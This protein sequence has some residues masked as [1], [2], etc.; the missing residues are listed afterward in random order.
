MSTGEGEIMTMHP[1]M[2]YRITTLELEQAAVRAERARMAAE[3][4]DQIVR[5]DG[6]LRRALRRLQISRAT[7]TAAPRA[8]PATPASESPAPST[9]TAVA[10][11]PAPAPASEPA[12][13]APVAQLASATVDA[14]RAGAARDREL[15]G[16]APHAA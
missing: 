2:S 9:A 12:P 4:A 10:E 7:A 1:S 6:I 8:V 5:R 15:V 16:C 13:V 11:A 3:H 14:S